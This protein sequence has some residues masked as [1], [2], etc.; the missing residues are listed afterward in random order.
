MTGDN[1][2][3]KL[4]IK[5][6]GLCAHCRRPMRETEFLEPSY[7]WSV[8]GNTDILE[9]HHTKSIAEG[10]KSR[11]KSTH[12]AYNTLKNMLL[13]HKECHYTIGHDKE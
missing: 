9:I 4:F 8:N 10:Y 6:A 11:S 5:Q 3:T 1:F 13:M 12:K 7:E 2:K